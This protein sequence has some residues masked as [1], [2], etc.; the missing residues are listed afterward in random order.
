MSGQSTMDALSACMSKVADIMK[1]I[2]NKPALS[3]IKQPLDTAS[4]TILAKFKELGNMFKPQQKQTDQHM[5]PFL[6]I[7]I[8]Q[9]L[10]KSIPLLIVRQIRGCKQ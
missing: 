2:G 10:T 1:T 9:H 7:Q 5:H 6:M 4:G 3:H 8:L